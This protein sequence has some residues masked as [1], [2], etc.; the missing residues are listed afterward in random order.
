MAHTMPDL[1]LRAEPSNR[2]DAEL[3]FRQLGLLTV[4][5]L[6]W[7]LMACSCLTGS[8]NSALRLQ[9]ISGL[10]L[11]GFFLSRFWQRQRKIRYRAAE[12]CLLVYAVSLRGWRL[13][14]RYPLDGF[15]G[16]YRGGKG[17]IAEVW[18]AGKNGGQDVL[19]DRIFLGTGVLQKHFAAGLANL[20]RA[21]GLPVLEPGEAI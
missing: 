16:L 2:H 10:L 17:S 1:P 14:A 13:A 15:A 8:A 5:S 19:L 4:A 6:V 11:S 9:Q 3:V 7:L 20:S 18:L 12:D 21:T